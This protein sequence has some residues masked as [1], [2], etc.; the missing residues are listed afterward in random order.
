MILITLLGSVLIE[1]VL[2]AYSIS[3]F[4]LFVIKKFHFGGGASLI[5]RVGF[6]TILITE[7]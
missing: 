5:S 2:I 3:I 7:T 1:T 4:F 6:M